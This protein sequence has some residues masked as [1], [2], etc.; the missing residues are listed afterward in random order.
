MLVC[1]LIG[2]NAWDDGAIT[3][4]FARTF[5]RHGRVALTP[6]SEVVEGFSSVSWFLL[7]SLLALARPSYRVTIALSQAL[8]VVSIGASTVLLARTCALLRLDRLFSAL[9][10]LAFVAWGCSF[11]EAG[12]GM[13]MGLLAAACL[14]IIN[15]L[16]SQRARLLPLC[17]GVVLALTTR[18]EAALYVGLLGLCVLSVPG[19]RAFWAMLFTSVVTVALLS[20]WRLAT[21]ADVVPNTIWAK[22]WPPYAAFSVADRLAGAVELLSFFVGPVVALAIAGRSGLRLGATLRARERALA[23]IAAPVVGAVVMGAL[24]GRH[25]GYYGRMPYFAFPPALLLV[26]LLLTDWVKAARSRLRVGLAVGAMAS[27]V[28][29]SMVG[30]PFG[31]LDAA[32]QGGAFGVTPHTYA[33]SGKVFRRFTAAADLEHPTILTSDIGGLALCC[34]EFKIVDL[35]FLSNR[36]LARQGP[37]AI[38]EVLD[39]ESPDLIE[40]HWHWTEVGKLYD[41][42]RFRADY[43]PA[44]AGGT[45]LWLR[46][47]VAARIE[48][49]GRGCWVSQQR[50]D[51]KRA[52]RDHR[53]AN[54]DVPYD[55]ASFER[56]GLVFTLEGCAGK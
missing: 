12:N 31:P 50:D 20:V 40:A 47:D 1:L 34:D 26:S 10:M 6:R 21:F 22:R 56:Q 45:R 16:L 3:L 49:A 19:R 28:A 4:A 32:R 55:R 9:T 5:A 27:A 35:A 2:D 41:L 54:T 52:L 13:E 29:V 24:I 33:E 11:S 7:N 48:R 36:T 14:L 38:G 39:A 25:W 51:L 8:A 44:F 17:A 23:I 30:F 18:F 53:Y 37:N 15:E 43:A 46:R 42:P